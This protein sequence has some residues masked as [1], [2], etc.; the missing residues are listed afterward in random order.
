MF[1]EVTKKMSVKTTGTVLLVV[2]MALAVFTA[3]PALI[4]QVPIDSVPE[5][6]LPIWNYLVIFFNIAQVTTIIA[7]TINVWGFLKNYFKTNY[8]EEYDFTKLGKTLAVYVGIITTLL[9]AIT[10]LSE[11]LPEPYNQ[12]LSAGLAIGASLL[13]ILDLTKKQLA[14]LGQAIRA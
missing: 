1:L 4:E 3:L 5:I 11:I 7:L 8:E 12:I 9:A 13:V 6:L 10:P 2:I 14:E